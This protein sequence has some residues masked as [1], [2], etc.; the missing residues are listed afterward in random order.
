MVPAA[1]HHV[2]GIVGL[3]DPRQVAFAPN[4]H[5]FVSRLYSCF[6]EREPV[7]VLT[8]GSEF[9]SFRRQSRRLQEAGRIEL[10][11][12]SADPWQ[13]FEKRFI[14]ALRSRDAP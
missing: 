12:V 4:T 13:T 8:T 14:A 2:A 1:Q 7:A 6:E 11:E 9:H 3:P 5:E 10:V